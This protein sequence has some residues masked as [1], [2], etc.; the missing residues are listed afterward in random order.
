[1]AE[2]KI[3][4]TKASQINK[5]ER[6]EIEIQ[7]REFDKTTGNF[8]LESEINKIKI[9]IPLVELEKKLVYRKKTAKLINFSDNE[10][11]V[12]IINLEDDKA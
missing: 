6:K 7:T 10:I 1:M 8:S 4:E 2:T 5:P 3:V 11:Q 12:D 9:S